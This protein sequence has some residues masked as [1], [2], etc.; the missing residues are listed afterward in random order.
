MQVNRYTQITPSVF[1]PMTM[2]EIFSVPLAKQKRHDDTLAQLDN[3]GAF[4]VNRLSE[5]DA[6]ARAFLDKYQNDVDAQVNSILDSGVNGQSIRGVR[7]LANRRNKWLSSDQE[8]GKMQANYQAY[9]DYK[10]TLDEALKSGDLPLARYNAL[11]GNARSEYEGGVAQ[12]KN[13]KLWA[14][15]QEVDVAEYL[16]PFAKDI[17]EN[18]VFIEQ[19]SGMYQDP[20]GSGL[21][22]DEKTGNEFHPQ[23]AI[24]NALYNYAMSNANIRSLLGQSQQ[25]GLIPDP[26]KYLENITRSM[27]ATYKKTN[28]Y[29]DRTHT[30]GDNG[31]GTNDE[32][33][34]N[35]A[36]EKYTA[37]QL[38]TGNNGLAQRIE[39]VLAGKTYNELSTVGNQ[40]G[41][42]VTGNP[43][44]GVSGN[45][46]SE[47]SYTM[48]D[49]EP[50][51]NELLQGL[52]EAGYITQGMQPGD[53]DYE[54]NF[55]ELESMG[56]IKEG[57][58]QSQINEMV[59]YRQNL[60]EIGSYLDQTKNFDYVH[61]VDSSNLFKTFDTAGN[62]MKT[63]EP[64]NIAKGIQAQADVRNWMNADG[65]KNMSFNKDMS[66]YNKEM[67]SKGNFI[68]SGVL[69]ARNYLYLQQEGRVAN[70]EALV[71]PYV[72]KIPQSNG[73]YETFF[74]SRGASEKN[75]SGYKAAHKV[76]EIWGK[77]GFRPDIPYKTD[78]NGVGVKVTNERLQDGG[79]KFEVLDKDGFTEHTYNLDNEDHLELLIEAIYNGGQQ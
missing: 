26:E 62:K 60:K 46:V 36:Y 49:Y 10:T 29:K 30:K 72:V 50:Q 21:W 9:Q 12:N 33:Q 17:S 22:I 7:A 44:A 57:M 25:L 38:N 3:L 43:Y 20:N 73:N 74:V 69:T 68:V 51:F 75:T 31:D 61:T 70:E 78:I 23:D 19:Y 63:T 35:T 4:D 45:G 24:N 52:T 64:E 59:L 34:L 2:Q 55:A 71:S 77:T 18:P 54:Q 39:D 13:L 66:S 76:N 53:V 56:A 27:D 37:G 1:D 65:S 42:S 8:G 11:L 28:V 79:Y 16:K 5:D 14:P 40:Q 58:S 41:V 15:A 48:G 47:I 67:I 6:T 32:N